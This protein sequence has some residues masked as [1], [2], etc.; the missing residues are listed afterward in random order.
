[1]PEDSRILKFL[2]KHWQW[3]DREFQKRFANA[4]GYVT[5]QAYAKVAGAARYFSPWSVPLQHLPYLMQLVGLPAFTALSEP[6]RRALAERAMEV[7]ADKGTRATID[8][9]LQLIVGE[10]VVV[11]ETLVAFIAGWSV[12]GDVCGPGTLQ[13][14]FTVTVPAGIPYSETELRLYLSYVTMPASQITIVYE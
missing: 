1:M 4:F 9:W 12:A 5:D 11:T 2:P 6:V 13:Y 7:W 14:A 3:S 10:G 8:L